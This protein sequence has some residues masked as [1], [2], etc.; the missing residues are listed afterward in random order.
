M[1]LQLQV[2]LAQHVGPVMGVAV[3]ELCQVLVVTACVTCWGCGPDS[4]LAWDVMSCAGDTKRNEQVSFVGLALTDG[5]Y[6]LEQCGSGKLRRGNLGYL[7][8]L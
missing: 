4:S 8:S 1:G 7:G 6:W 2:T 5:G 3:H